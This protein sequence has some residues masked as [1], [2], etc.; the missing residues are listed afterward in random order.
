MERVKDDQEGKI[1][2]QKLGGGSW[3]LGKRIIKPGE[4][5]FAFPNEIP[6]SMKDI[7][8]PTTGAIDWGTKKEE[9]Q[10]V[11]PITKVTYTVE[12]SVEVVQRGKSNLWWNVVDKE[13]NVLNEKALKKEDAEV[14]PISYNLVSST[15]KVIN[16][17]PLS[18]EDAETLLTA[19]GK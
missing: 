7:I 2:F 5:F 12:P 16:E 17:K 18:K 9:V 1:Q 6:N 14:F 10:P 19:L 3:R 15:G 4:K 13:G 11:Y 8:V